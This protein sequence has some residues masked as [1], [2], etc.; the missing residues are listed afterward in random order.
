MSGRLFIG[1][2]GNLQH[3]WYEDDLKVRPVNYEFLIRFLYLAILDT[4]GLFCAM[5]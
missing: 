4:K 1:L 2:Y 3:E 5:S